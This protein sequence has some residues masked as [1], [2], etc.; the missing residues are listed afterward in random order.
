[1]RLFLVAFLLAPCLLADGPEFD[2]AAIKPFVQPKTGGWGSPRGGPGTTDP[3]HITLPGGSL[4]RLL[5]MAFGLQPYQVIGPDSL[6]KDLFDFAIAIPEGAT[7]E[8]VKIMWRNLLVSRFGLKYH[9]EQREFPVD[10]LIVGPKGHKLAENNDPPP[11]P[12]P[13]GT[14]PPATPPKIENG[15]PILTRAMTMTMTKAGPNGVTATMFS[16]GQTMR[17]LT[18]MLSAE[19][20]HPVIDKTGL[21]GKYDFTLEYLPN[22]RTVGDMSARVRGGADSNGG[23][24]SPAVTTDLP[25]DLPNALQQQL[26]LRLV[27]GKDKLDV[28]IVDKIERVPTEN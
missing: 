11:Q 13:D 26:G 10:D 3:T 25:L 15:R 27:K 14:F 2:A 20:S 1:M 9:I 22:S 7:R 28:V 16:R 24:N 4:Q 8:D 6:D 21:P 18:D 23:A 12:G 19:L 17:G 5:T